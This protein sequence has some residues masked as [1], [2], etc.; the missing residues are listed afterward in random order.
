M[1]LPRRLHRWNVT[2]ARA[3]A[4]Q[5]ELASRVDFS[6]LPGVVR[7]V[8]G[9][10]ATFTRDEKWCVASVVLWDLQDQA[11]VEQ[12]VQRRRL[13]FPYVPGLLSFREAPALLAAIGKLRV[14][15]DILMCDGQG[16]A[17]PRRFGIACHVGVLTGLSSMG[18]AKSILVGEHGVLKMA[19]GSKVPLMDRGERVGTVLRTRDGVNPVYVSIGHRIDLPGAEE[20]VLRCS[21]GFRLPEPTRLAHQLCSRERSTT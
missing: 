14:R 5:R 3:I 18:C 10:D 1:K 11:V 9:L 4:I 8:A 21:G 12:H 6:K 15:P 7:Y 20:L 19:R 17:H 16:L 13:V 2:P